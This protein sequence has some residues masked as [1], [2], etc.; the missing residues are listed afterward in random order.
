MKKE[1]KEIK[2]H[3]MVI[4]KKDST[5]ASKGEIGTVVYIYPSGSFEVEFVKEKK[6]VLLAPEE[7]KY[8]SDGII[9]DTGTD[10]VQQR[11]ADQDTLSQGLGSEGLYDNRRVDYTSPK[12]GKVDISYKRRTVPGEDDPCTNSLQ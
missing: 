12:Q 10:P 7:V 6:V 11:E 1:K 3:D 4:V 5:H 8:H 2:E 9:R